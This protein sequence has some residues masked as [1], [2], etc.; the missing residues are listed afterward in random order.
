MVGMNGSPG[1]KNANAYLKMK[2]LSIA[3]SMKT[4]WDFQTLTCFAAAER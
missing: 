4:K 2:E 3:T 1:V